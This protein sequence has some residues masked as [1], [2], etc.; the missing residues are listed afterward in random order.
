[1]CY[2]HSLIYQV[3]LSWHKYSG[4][5]FANT[6]CELCVHMLEAGCGSEH[7]S[8]RQVATKWQP[9][10]GRLGFTLG[11]SPAPF[12]EGISVPGLH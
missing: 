6:E 1:M 4:I 9:H 11:K 5:H 10:A 7:L 2:E 8:G 3:R 12:Q